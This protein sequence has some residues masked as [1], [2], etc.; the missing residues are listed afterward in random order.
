MADSLPLKNLTV[1]DA[2]ARILAGASRLG[3]ETVAV[4]HSLGRILAAP[5]TATRAQPPFDAS[6]MD[7]WAIRR[8]DYQPGKPFAVVG[9]SAAG[10]AFPRAVQ[11]GEA[12]RIFTGAPVPAGADLVVIQEEAVRDGDTVRF[13]AGEA[14]RSNI[15]PA[16]GDF[17]AGD[18][19][20]AEGVVIDP[21]RLSLV[22]SAGLAEVPVA[23]RPR[24]AILATGDE[25]VPPGQ[26][27]RPDQIFESGSF[28]LAA[29]VEAWGGEAFRLSAQGDDAG[30]I[31]A[32][33]SSCLSQ[34]GPIQADLI[35][36]IGGASVGDHDLV[37][38]A[39]KTL[40][41]DLVVETVAVRPGKPT[42]SGTLADGRRV[43]GLPGNPAS[44]LVCAELFLK[45][46]LAALS[47]GDPE[48]RLSA[49]R[50]VAPL[51]ATGPREHWMRA[52]LAIDA[53][54]RLTA[55]AFPDQ[56]SSL[57]G[58]FSQAE[59]LLRRRPGAPAALAGDTVEVLPLRRG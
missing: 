26:A 47:G 25:L 38:P 2:R 34:E 1:E 46:L 11:A 51:S 55:S 5:V 22:A 41:L 50:L 37:K 48:V 32:A 59:A 39:L 36:T 52:R 30:A 40:G 43:L 24:V 35:V 23:R 13:E 17:Q 56:D 28:S 16:G 27:P 14:P 18:V 58:V 15:R 3:V 21:W 31:A 33:V 44:A 49:A 9:E 6:A 7:G 20:L 4:E 10:K 19:L 45:P 12:V 8:A 54:G 29:L 53:E 42:W 57:I